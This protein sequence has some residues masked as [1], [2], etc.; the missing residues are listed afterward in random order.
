MTPTQQRAEFKRMRDSIIT[1]R[2]QVAILDEQVEAANAEIKHL[3]ASDELQECANLLPDSR[4]MDPPDGGSPTIAEQLKR[5]IADQRQG[6]V[7]FCLKLSNALGLRT[8]VRDGM[9]D[10]ILAEIKRLKEVNSK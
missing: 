1:L 5:M 6:D 7:D 9:R 10:D 4:Y 2:K 8:T 3:K